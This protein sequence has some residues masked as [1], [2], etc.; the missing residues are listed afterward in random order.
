MDSLPLE[1]S[2]LEILKPETRNSKLETC[3]TS[4]RRLLLRLVL[5]WRLLLLVIALLHVAAI[6][7]DLHLRSEPLVV[8]VLHNLTNVHI[9]RAEM[10]RV[11]SAGVSRKP[12]PSIYLFAPRGEFRKQVLVL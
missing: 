10:Q 9:S 3:L 12:V 8:R 5:L 11:V 2:N 1:L 6:V 4:L 7:G